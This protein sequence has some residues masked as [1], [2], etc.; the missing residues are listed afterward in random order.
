MIQIWCWSPDYR[1]RLGST[2]KNKRLGRG[3]VISRAWA[4]P[5]GWNAKVWIAPDMKEVQAN[6]WE[7]FFY[8][9]YQG[10]ASK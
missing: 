10:R 9:F 8:W 5:G 3:L 7:E 1:P 2:V 6:F 4:D